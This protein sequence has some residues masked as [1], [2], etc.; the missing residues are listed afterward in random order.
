MLHAL[1][2]EIKRNQG[3]EEQTGVGGLCCHLGQCDTWAHAA[4]EGNVWAQEPTKAGI[5]V[6]VCGPI[7]LKA[8]WMPMIWVLGPTKAGIYVDLC[9]PFYHQGP[10]LNWSCFSPAASAGGLPPNQNWP[11]R[12]GCRRAGH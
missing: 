6:D 4:T 9:D 3:G 12:H 7:L 2:R 10:L 8:I 1:W 11:H 5:C